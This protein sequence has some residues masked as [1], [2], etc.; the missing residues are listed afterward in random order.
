MDE[1]KK[2]APTMNNDESD[3]LDRIATALE[4]IEVA[5]TAMAAERADRFGRSD[6]LNDADLDRARRAVARRRSRQERPRYDST[7]WKLM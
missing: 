1:I 3:P 4:G 7:G 2:E 5:L 6:E